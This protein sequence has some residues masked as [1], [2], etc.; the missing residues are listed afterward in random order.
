MLKKSAL[1]LPASASATREPALARAAR[2]ASENAAAVLA[3]AGLLAVWELVCRYGGVPRWLLPAP[4]AILAELWT[5]RDI[6]PAHVL[7]TTIEVAGG[8]AAAVLTGV[9]L[10]V[11]IVSSPLAR[12]LAYP[13]LLVLQSVP[14]VALAPIILLWAGYGSGSKIL[15]AAV[16]AFFP[17]IINTSAGM[18]AVPA[19]LLELSRSLKSPTLK[20]FWK[21][22][23]PYAMPYV[24]SGMKVAMALSLIGA[25][26]GEF[27]GA[28][29]GLGYLILTFSSTMNTALVF[30]A[31][32]LL[33]I[34]GIALFYIVCAAERIFCPWYV[35]TNN[36]RVL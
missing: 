4:S 22:R 13:I 21:V 18:Q 29:K 24:F 12:K 36:D 2:A 11:L 19:E 14:K 1:S 9:P 7:T 35:S 6:L 33:A 10:S 26:V 31:M 20:V 17:I 3:F 15:I 23:L 8:F 27:V 5:A 28:D 32:V 34:L 16:T 30:G 25:V